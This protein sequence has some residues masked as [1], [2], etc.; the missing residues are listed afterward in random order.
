MMRLLL[1]SLSLIAGFH[2]S[3][4]AAPPP[5]TTITD[6]AFVAPLT[7]E[8]RYRWDKI[9]S[10]GPSGR[11]RLPASVTAAAAAAARASPV[12]MGAKR[13]TDNDAGVS[14]SSFAAADGQTSPGRG[15]DADDGA[16]AA[17]R[18]GRRRGRDRGGGKLPKKALKPLQTRLNDMRLDFSLAGREPYVAGAPPRIAGQQSVSPPTA[19]AAGSGALPVRQ[20]AYSSYRRRRRPL[21]ALC[22]PKNQRPQGC[23]PLLPPMGIQTPQVLV[24]QHVA[25]ELERIDD[26]SEF[27]SDLPCVTTGTCPVPAFRCANGHTWES[28]GYPVC[29]YCPICADTRVM[30]RFRQRRDLE[31]M[32]GV[33]HLASELG[34][35]KHVVS[36]VRCASFGAAQEAHHCRYAPDGSPVWRRFP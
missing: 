13:A 7:G 5:T 26:L 24:V 32:Q 30:K 27:K 35:Q 34:L 19:A 33:G 15:G 21:N 17:A 8:R 20:A 14:S 16:D 2:T 31:V 28:N 23:A 18:I 11:S 9:N 22:M 3:A 6:L 10:V 4:P 36:E 29:F 12:A 25:A 1:S